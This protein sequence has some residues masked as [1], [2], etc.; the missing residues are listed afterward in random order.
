MKIMQVMKVKKA[1][2]KKSKQKQVAEDPV[3]VSAR[4]CDEQ[5]LVMKKPAKKD[6]NMDAQSV[7]SHA[8]SKTPSL[9]EKI[10]LLRNCDLPVADKIKLMNEKLSH[11]DWNKINGRFATAKAKDAEL[12]E[13]A[14]QTPRAFQ[15]ALTGAWVLDPAKGEVFNSLTCNISASHIMTKTMQWESEKS[16]LKK[17]SQ[18][19]LQRHIN[20]GRII[21]RED[22]ATPGVY[23]YKDTKN[24][25]EVQQIQRTKQKQ[26][27]QK[28]E[29]VEEAFEDEMNELE[30]SWNNTNIESYKPLSLRDVTLGEGKGGS[31]GHKGKGKGNQ[32]APE[33][34]PKKKLKS[35]K[36]VLTSTIKSLGA[37]GFNQKSMPPKLKKALQQNIKKLEKQ[38]EKINTVQE[39]SSD[40]INKFVADTNNLVAV[41]KSMME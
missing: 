1:S 16:I 32:P 22:P 7:L 36:A 4:P 6:M 27:S 8:L 14:L 23:E 37:W 15:R 33:D 5:P 12:N 25:A 13:K 39:G 2:T 18:D 9:N 19:E 3:N 34:D 35:I 11:P 38:A 26:L 29:I 40:E 20:S 41:C 17:W 30:D 24:I 31:G 28:S 21:W 10:K